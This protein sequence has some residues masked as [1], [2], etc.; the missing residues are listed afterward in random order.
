MAAFDVITEDRA[1][2]IRLLKDWTAAAEAHDPGPGN[3][4]N[5]RRR[6]PL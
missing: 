2:L 3:R 4:S 5:G 6:R 1:A